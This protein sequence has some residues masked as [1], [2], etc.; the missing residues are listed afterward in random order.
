MSLKNYFL[1]TADALPWIESIA[2]ALLC[3]MQLL[4]YM[5]VFQGGGGNI[6]FSSLHT[7]AL[8]N[9]VINQ[10]MPT[11]GA[12]LLLWPEAALGSRVVLHASAAG[13]LHAA[14]L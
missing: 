4:P 10:L 6:T 13:W 8:K 2:G 1:L 9:R 7:V 3:F 11:I 12:Q 5:K 14:A